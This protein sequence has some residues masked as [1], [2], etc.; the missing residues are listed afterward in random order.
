MS[1]VMSSVMSWRDMNSRIDEQG[2][3]R[4]RCD[5]LLGELERLERW[6][7]RAV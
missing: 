6:E 5:E 3:V 7:R 4:A 1:S 2:S